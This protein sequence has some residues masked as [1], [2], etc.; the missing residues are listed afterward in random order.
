MPQNSHWPPSSILETEMRS[1]FGNCSAWKRC[2]GEFTSVCGGQ[3]RAGLRLCLPL[4]STGCSPERLLDAKDWIPFRRVFFELTKPPFHPAWLSGWRW[5]VCVHETGVWSWGYWCLC[6]STV[7]GWGREASPFF[8]LSPGT[9]VSSSPKFTR[10]LDEKCS[11]RLHKYLLS[12]RMNW[13]QG[14]A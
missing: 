11:F 14:D 3:P 12:V 1:E 5:V 7:R 6:R 4:A 10:R 9:W 8:C 2:M 13:I